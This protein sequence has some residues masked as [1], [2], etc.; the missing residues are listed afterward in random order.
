LVNV[1]YQKPPKKGLI[2]DL[3]DTL[4]AGLVGEVGA[5]AVCW[6]QDSHAQVHG[7]YQQMLGHLADCGV[8]IGVSSKNELAYVEEALGR[9]DLFLDAESLF[10]VYANWSPKSDSVGKILRDWNIGQETV[11]FV[12][13]NPTELAEVQRA[14]P[15][16]TCLRFPAKDPAGVWNLLG[17]LRDLF[18]K[19]E[20]LEEDGLRRNSLRVS[21]GVRERV[22]AGGST[23]FLQTLHG[24]VTVDYRKNPA[25]KR[26]LELINKTNQFNLN[27]VRIREGQ[28]VRLIE[29][30]ETL[31]AVVS[32]RDKFGP[33]G[34]IA[35]LVAERK[36]GSVQ[37]SNW[38]MSCRAFSRAIELHTLD[39]LFRQ[40]GANVIE[41]DY[42]VT[43]RNQPLQEF[44]KRVGVEENRLSREQFLANSGALPHEVNELLA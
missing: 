24:V 30:S 10:P 37:V 19:P 33:L 31:V 41:F 14:F 25:D 2:T 21:A 42:Q 22:E 27:G 9:S 35:V 26:P 40:T 6:Q 13:D 32:Y 43:E 4:W 44:F 11:V 17:E 28:W 18:G 20:V 8:L 38:V 1:L 36:A 12:D 5:A 39:S 34:K 29:P 23:E 7:L 16:I 15:R 3:D